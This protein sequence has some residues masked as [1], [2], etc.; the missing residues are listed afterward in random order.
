MDEYQIMTQ[1]L[2]D[3]NSLANTCATP[4]EAKRR[5]QEYLHVWLNGP[6]QPPVYIEVAYDE[7]EK[8]YVILDNR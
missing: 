5:Q 1:H 3:L 4:E 7:D 6:D 2:H 8:Q